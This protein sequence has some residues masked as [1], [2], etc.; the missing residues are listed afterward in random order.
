MLTE[1]AVLA[2]LA[3]ILGPDLHRD[4]VSLGLVK[5]LRMQGGKVSFA[6]ELTTPACPMRKQM[7]E[8]TR[9]AVASLP[10][11]Q[12]VDVTVT[13]CVTTSLDAGTTAAAS[14]PLLVIR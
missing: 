12:Q 8:A 5:N 3:T 2:T 13:S 4:I 6:I 14:E 7:E 10:G 11:V 9:Q 1:Q